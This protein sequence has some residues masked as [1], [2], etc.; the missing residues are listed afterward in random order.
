MLEEDKL[1]AARQ[2]LAEFRANPDA[3]KFRQAKLAVAERKLLK[4]RAPKRQA[5]VL[6]RGGIFS[7]AAFRVVSLSTALIG[8]SIIVA[9][10]TQLGHDDS[11]VSLLTI[12]GYTVEG[13][14]IH[15]TEGFPEIRHGQVW[16]LITPIF[17]HFSVL[18]LL[19]NML[20]LRDLGSLIEARA[21]T[22]KLLLLVLVTAIASNIGQYL[23]SGPSFGGM[24]GVVYGLFGYIWMRGK[25]DPSSGMF[26]TDQTILIMVGWYLLCLTGMIGS[27]ANTA[28]TVGLVLGM[29]IGYLAARI[30]PVGFR[31]GR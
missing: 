12:T 6:N 19:F 21:S 24:S 5:R 4:A 25:F 3:E 30:R 1:D 18:H 8:I 16:R 26:L 22:L 9:V 11:V 2:Y 28:H 31:R 29:G 10:G 7:G 14:S 13:D 23:M 15:W 27:I 17:V 20:W